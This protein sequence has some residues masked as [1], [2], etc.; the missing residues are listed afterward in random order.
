MLS[1]LS[2]FIITYYI[3]LV[4]LLSWGRQKG[5]VV[6][7]NNGVLKKSEN[8]QIVLIGFTTALIVIFRIQ[9]FWV[10]LLFLAAYGAWLMVARMQKSFSKTASTKFKKLN[11]VLSSL[12][13]ALLFSTGIY[14]G[15]STG[16]S[17]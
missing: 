1:S 2:I 14:L 11:F 9:A 13:L 4:V 3:C 8:I 12:Y 17:L 15:E 7:P 5:Y 10:C 16:F 6:Q